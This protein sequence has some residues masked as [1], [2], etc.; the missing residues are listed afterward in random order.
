M[1]LRPVV[2]ALAGAG[3]PDPAGDARRLF[4]WAYQIGAAAPEPQNRDRPN[5]M[6][7]EMFEIA[8]AKRLKRQPVSQITGRRAFWRHDFDVT[9]DVLDPRPDTE[10]LID[11]ALSE[12]FSRVLDLGTGSGCIAISL[13]ADRPSAQGV[14]VD[15]SEAALRVAHGNAG[16][17]GVAD[18][19]DL[20]VSDWFST[21]EGVFDLIVSNPPYIAQDEMPGLA[22]EVRDWE[23]HLALTDGD[24]GLACYRIIAEGALDHLCAGGRLMVEIG[25]TQA[26]AVS[27]LFRNAGLVDISV[28]PDLDGR[29]R[30]VVGRNSS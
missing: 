8:V 9:E 30:V 13:L 22:P 12:P 6:T 29:D 24:D 3:V 15:V 5:D 21:V 11:H 4:D 20:R 18:R 25:P 16:R 14:A 19:L 17:I 26:Q 27:G 23:P 28:L 10:T 7:L 1:N 2:T